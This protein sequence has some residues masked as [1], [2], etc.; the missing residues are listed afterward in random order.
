ML[1]DVKFVIILNSNF[2]TKNL[3]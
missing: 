2:E 3:N 1:R